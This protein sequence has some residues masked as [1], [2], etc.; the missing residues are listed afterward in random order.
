MVQSLVMEQLTAQSDQ[1]ALGALVERIVEAVHPLRIILFGSAAR[2]EMGPD[3]DVDFLVVMPE[4][5][6]RLDTAGFLHTRLHGIPLSVDILV[7][8]PSDLERYRDSV[9]LV[10][11]TILNEGRDIYPA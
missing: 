2:G 10:Y 1:E 7:A 3:S 9:G 5:T 11:G 8:T 6:H 4:G